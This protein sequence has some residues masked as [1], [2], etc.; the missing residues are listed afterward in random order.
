VENAQESEDVTPSDLPNASGND[1]QSDTTTDTTNTMGIKEALTKGIEQA[2]KQVGTENGFYNDEAIKILLPENL[3]KADALVRKVG[4]TQLSEALVL[5][6]NRA[7]EKAAPQALDIFVSAISGMQ[8]DDAMQILSGKETAATD[9]LKANTSDALN[10]AFYPIVKDSM[11]ELG[12]IK[13]Y[14]DYQSKIASNPLTKIVDMDINRYVTEESING[15]FTVVAQE[16][17]NIRQNP[18]ARTT[19]LLQKVFGNLGK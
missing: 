7:A 13:L 4:G 14:N 16:E 19:D 12:V 1:I 11:E 17:E 5:K 18:A 9:Y 3:R 15:L 10:D 2:V 8:I 6:M